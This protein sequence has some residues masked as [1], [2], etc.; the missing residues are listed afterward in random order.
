MASKRIQTRQYSL[1][2]VTPVL[3]IANIGADN[4]Y[5]IAIP[6]KGYV[7]NVFADTLTAFDGTTNTITVT[8]G[9]TV[10]VNAQDTKTTGRETA[11][12]SNKYYPSGGVI[13]VSMA[14]TGTATVGAAI[15]V[16]D[17]VLIDRVNEVQQ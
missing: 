15:V 11:A 3:G 12:V 4:G 13:T 17:Y 7:T 2:A 8:D 16:V 9:T 10:F 6:P 14:Q 1:K 5:T